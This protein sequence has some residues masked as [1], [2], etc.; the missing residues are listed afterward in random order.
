M[1]HEF[2]PGDAFPS[3][4]VLVREFGVSRETVR[5]ALNGLAKE[6]WI[7]RHR[8]QGTFVCPA[9]RD[10]TDRRVTGLA[11]DLTDLGTDTRMKILSRGTVHLPRNIAGRLRVEPDDLAYK[12]DRVRIFEGKPLSFIETYLPVDIG[13]NIPNKTLERSSVMTEL[14]KTLRLPFHEEHQTIEAITVDAVVAKLLHIP[15]GAPALLLSRLLRLRDNRTVLFRSQYRADR[16]FYTVHFAKPASP[17]APAKTR[18]RA[19]R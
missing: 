2:R 4:Q 12:L 5:E 3:D 16:Y 1:Q 15:V 6:G 8:G 18:R 11:E 17:A 14:R 9:P 7:T 19:P 13:E 10:Q